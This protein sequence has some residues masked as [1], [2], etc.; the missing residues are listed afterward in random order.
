MPR[1]RYD[2]SP[3]SAGSSTDAARGS[4]GLATARDG[5]VITITLDRPDDQN[6][7]TRDLLIALQGIVDRLGGDGEIQAVVLTGG[8][9]EFFSMGILNPAVRATYTK[10]QILDLVRIA[11]R[12]YDALEALPQI[13]IAAL[14]GIARAGAAELAL[15]CDLRLA[16]SHATFALPE[17]RWG[18]FPGAGGP[19]RLPSIVGRARA[20]ELICT[21]REVDAAEMEK[22]GLVLAVHP[23]GRLLPEAQALAARISASGPLAT[24]GAKRIMN[25]RNAAGFAAARALSD[26]LRHELEWSRD[27]DEGMAAHREGRPPRFTGR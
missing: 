13:V 21:G 22:L 12:L 15:A 25:V 20:L 26:A 23:A 11:N 4:E 9:T 2:G 19:V 16:A 17:A 24:R 8:G 27:V 3:M 10:E 6:R 18:G 7:L 5:G 1:L 14:N